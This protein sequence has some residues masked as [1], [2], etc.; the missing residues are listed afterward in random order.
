MDRKSVASRVYHL[1][2]FP[3]TA[4]G[5][6]LFWIRGFVPHVGLAPD[7][8]LCPSCTDMDLAASWYLTSVWEF[9]YTVICIWALIPAADAAGSG[10]G[11]V[12]QR[13][14]GTGHDQPLLYTFQVPGIPVLRP[15]YW[16][17]H[18]ISCF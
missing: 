4:Q 9:A 10:E 18:C 12:Y 3:A 16:Y 13:R 7:L 11:G 17:L 6:R 15:V 1:G 14:P 5:M 2:F 8:G